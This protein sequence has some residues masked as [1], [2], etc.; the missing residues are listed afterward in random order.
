MFYVL[1][2]PGPP[3]YKWIEG[4]LTKI[5]QTSR[6]DNVWPEVWQSLSK[7]QKIA[8]TA[9][10]EIEKVKRDAARNKRGIFE[11]SA[12]DKDYLK[13]MSEVRA[14]MSIRQPLLYLF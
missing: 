12:D 13:I 4:R 1:R 2:P 6:P 8:E 7:K 5:Q 14:K 11:V 9:K 3:G 10:W